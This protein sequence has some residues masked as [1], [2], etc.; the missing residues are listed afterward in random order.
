MARSWQSTLLTIGAV[1]AALFAMRYLLPILLP[2]GIG[3]ALALCAEP[4]VALFT[5]KFHLRRSLA[6][7]FGVSA[8]ICFVL[9][10]LV[11]A[12]ALLVRQV[13]ALTRIVP[14]VEEAAKWGI[15]SL[16]KFLQTMAENAP[17]G[18]GVYLS[19]SIAEFFSSGTALLDRAVSFF[20]GIAG[21]VL[22]QV[23][24][25]ALG[26]GTALIS[27][28]MISAKLPRIRA[29]MAHFATRTGIDRVLPA[30]ARM[31]TALWGWLR[32]QLRLSGIT[33]LLVMMGL[34]LLRVSYA[35]VW[36]LIV[37]VVDA[38]PVLGTGTVL[39]PWAAV[40]FLQG[41][42]ARAIG[43]LGVYALVA[44]VR[45]VLEP[46]FVGKQLGIDPLVTLIALYAG[47]QL[48][49]LGGMI[50]APMVTAA[51]GGALKKE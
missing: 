14:S 23:P 47:F 16:S 51:V 34:V 43:L 15:A 6:A 37:A 5:R 46:K 35:P 49:G 21:G 31:R 7:A 20:L 48:W 1:V 25:G 27:A 28:Y 32:A 24:D 45:S 2:F 10:A 11:L 26:I 30:A 12:G 19:A 13:S 4:M 33:Y 8:A 41:N 42:G 39:V 22:R 50:L 17:A 36:A 29:Q 40:C 3:L 18:L 44:L 9:I 38:F